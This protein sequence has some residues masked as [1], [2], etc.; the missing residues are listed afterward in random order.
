MRSANTATTGEL[1]KAV[2]AEKPT[3][4]VEARGVEQVE[5]RER[6]VK[7][8]GTGAVSPKIPKSLK[9]SLRGVLRYKLN[10]D[11]IG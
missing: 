9:L 7:P 3:E 11:Q 5:E 1:R 8:G 6:G 2:G 10:I 4:R